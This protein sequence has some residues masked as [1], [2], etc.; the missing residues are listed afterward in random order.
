[1][2]TTHRP[3][4]KKFRL[5]SLTILALLGQATTN[6][7]HHELTCSLTDADFGCM[8]DSCVQSLDWSN[9]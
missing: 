8:T 3:L 6:L 2:A 1:M 4:T 5:I 9:Q 7:T